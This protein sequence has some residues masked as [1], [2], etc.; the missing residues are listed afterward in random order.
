MREKTHIFKLS[1]IST[2]SLYVKDACPKR[3]QEA[4]NISIGIKQKSYLI[5]SRCYYVSKAKAVSALISD[6]QKGCP[7]KK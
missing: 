5:C 2:I 6:G 4:H 3:K 7:H 1:C